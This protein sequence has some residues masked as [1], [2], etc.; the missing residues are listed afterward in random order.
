M[1]CIQIR[2]NM[3]SLDESEYREW[4]R[5]YEQV[6]RVVELYDNLIATEIDHNRVNVLR[7]LR[8][9]FLEDNK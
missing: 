7:R 6:D 9:G 4:Q 2:K 3:E 5:A 8:S 1:D